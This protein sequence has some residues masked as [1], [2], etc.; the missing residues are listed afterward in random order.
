M[1]I[2]VFGTSTTWGAW[3]EEGGWADRIK[4]YCNQK[5]VRENLGDKYYKVIYNLGIDGDRSGDVLERF[6]NEVWA[7]RKID[8][9]EEVV[10]IFDVGGNDSAFVNDKKEFWTPLGE[11]HDNL[12]K[13]IAKAKK[14][15]DKIVFMSF[16]P[17]EDKKV[18]PIP[19]APHMSYKM[20]Y[21]LRFNSVLKMLCKEE[22]V[23]FIDVFGV[24]SKLKP[25]TI[26]NDG[27][28][29]NSE[30]HRLIYELVRDYLSNK[31]II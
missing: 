23:D 19:W 4:K 8:L 6:D 11:Y 21:V 10:V 17:V 15:T 5:R 25:E 28:H 22:K 27:V 26:L 12:R 7:R 24:L 3:D 14:L 29:P 1:I 18:D 16:H 9:Q 31:N 30:G 2:L 20:E 13:L